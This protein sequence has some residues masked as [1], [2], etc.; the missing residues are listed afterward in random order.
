METAFSVHASNGMRALAEPRHRS[1][2]PG[3][4][5]AWTYEAGRWEKVRFSGAALPYGLEPFDAAVE[6]FEGNGTYYVRNKA[7]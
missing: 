1:K 3:C 7:A 6:L 4:R 5:A 2:L